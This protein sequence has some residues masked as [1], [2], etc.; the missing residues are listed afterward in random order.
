[1]SRELQLDTQK[2]IGR[3]DDDGIGW[4]IFNQPERHNALS[5]EMWQG[6]GDVLESYAGDPDVPSG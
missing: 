4:L 6:I 5:L 3:V 2:I 1:M